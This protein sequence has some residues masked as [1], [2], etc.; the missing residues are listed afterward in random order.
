LKSKGEKAS[1]ALKN[2]DFVF[3][4][5][6][7]TDSFSHDG[8]CAGKK[9]FI[10]KVDKE[11]IPILKKTGA[12][13]AISGDHCTPCLLGNHS[14]H[15]VPILFWGLGFRRDKVKSFDELSCMRG[16]MGHLDGWDLFPVILNAMGRAKKVGT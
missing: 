9:K 5:V 13:I 15:E 4:H 8:D 6:K 16:G 10:E 2:H 3:V 14:G 1:A 12:N 11:L 7:A